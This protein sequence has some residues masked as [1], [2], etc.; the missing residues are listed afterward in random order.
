MTI[1]GNRAIVLMLQ[2]FGAMAQDNLSKLRISL[3]RP[4]VQYTFQGLGIVFVEPLSGINDIPALVGEARW[5]SR[6]Q[7]DLAFR[8]AETDT[9]AVEAIESVETALKVVEPGYPAPDKQTPPDSHTRTILDTV[10]INI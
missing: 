9:D 5:E 1:T 3:E 4:S 8:I 6:A 10:T 2:A 7:L